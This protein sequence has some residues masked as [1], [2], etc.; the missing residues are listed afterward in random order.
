MPVR[1]NQ[2]IQ[3]TTVMEDFGIFLNKYSNFNLADEYHAKQDE[4][5]EAEEAHQDTILSTLDDEIHS[6]NLI[7]VEH[8]S[9]G[10]TVNTDNLMEWLKLYYTVEPR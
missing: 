10:Y 6:S 2:P 3:Q 4:R 5:V 7:V 8:D 9:E 1:V